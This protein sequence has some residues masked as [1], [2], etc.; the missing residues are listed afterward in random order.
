MRE[1]DLIR[2]STKRKKEKPKK[3]GGPKICDSVTQQLHLLSDH[4]WNQ[5]H[6]DNMIYEGET[7]TIK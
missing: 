1:I 6:K 2:S 3:I 4:K 5:W 7:P